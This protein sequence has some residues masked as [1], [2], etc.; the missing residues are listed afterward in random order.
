MLRRLKRCLNSEKDE[1]IFDIVLYG[2]SVKGKN[3]PNDVDL[4]VIFKSGSLKERLD[5]IQSIKKKIDMSVDIKGILWEELFQ[6]E[7]FARTG[8]FLEGVSVFDEKKFARKIGF[9]GSV[10]FFYNLKDKTHS[11]KVKFN[12]VLSGRNSKGLI[13]TLEGKHLAPGV[14]EIPIDKSLE[15]EE[16]LKRYSIRFTKRS[17][18]NKI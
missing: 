11:E 10:M 7:F 4:L 16:V 14:V 13:E 8:V 18:L 15:F 9:E 3:R 1:N 6:P 17:M 2:S 12:Y 5:R